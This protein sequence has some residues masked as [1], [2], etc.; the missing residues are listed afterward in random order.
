MNRDETIDLDNSHAQPSPA[1]QRT[2]IDAAGTVSGASSRLAQLD[3]L[4]VS[5][6]SSSALARYRNY[7]EALLGRDEDEAA[8]ASTLTLFVWDLTER[9]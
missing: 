8:I 4:A 9:R 3:E 1:I 5:T 2:D 7:K 6:L